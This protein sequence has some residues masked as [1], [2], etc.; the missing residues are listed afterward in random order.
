MDVPKMDVISA[1]ANGAITLEDVKKQTYAAT[2]AGC[3]IQ[4]V[5]RLIEYL[6][7]PEPRR[8]RAKNKKVTRGLS[9]PPSI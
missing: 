3:C 7:P 2:G 4:Q 6:H 1:I 5:K 9:E 8:R